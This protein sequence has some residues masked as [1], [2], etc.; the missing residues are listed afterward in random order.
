M[1]LHPRRT[2]EAFMNQYIEALFI[3][4]NPVPRDI[5]LAQLKKWFQPLLDAESAAP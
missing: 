4:D 3:E 5:S 2:G 1:L